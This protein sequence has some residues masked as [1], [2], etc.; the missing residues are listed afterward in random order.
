LFPKTRAKVG[1]TKESQLWQ[2]G[3]FITSRMEKLTREVIN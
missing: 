1:V 3:N 2:V